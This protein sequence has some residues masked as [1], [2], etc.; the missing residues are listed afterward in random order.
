[1]GSIVKKMIALC[2]VLIV[3]ASVF[4]ITNTSAKHTTIQSNALLDKQ[5]KIS[6]YINDLINNQE[7][8]TNI[9]EQKGINEY[10]I[11][12]IKQTI[13]KIFQKTHS[14]VGTVSLSIIAAA[15]TFVIC[16]ILYPVVTPTVS[17]VGFVSGFLASRSEVGLI[18]GIFTGIIFSLF[19]TF[20]WP[21][22]ISYYVFVLVISLISG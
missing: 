14:E 21:F 18:G 5:Q 11:N 22:A 15:T 6:E 9:L 3:V 12:N 19:L 1:M 4:P 20:A 16:L 7:F 17:L 13:S 8:K 2:L 10:A